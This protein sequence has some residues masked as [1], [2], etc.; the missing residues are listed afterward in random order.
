[1]PCAES[2]VRNKREKGQE[3]RESFCHR[4]IVKNVTW[5]KNL[6]KQN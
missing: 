4:G 3:N 5:G 2:R 1:M 6:S